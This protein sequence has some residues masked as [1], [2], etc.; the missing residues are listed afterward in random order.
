MASHP[1]V[2]VIDEFTTQRVA[3]TSKDEASR[4]AV[5]KPG[6]TDF[7]RRFENEMVV[8]EVAYKELKATRRQ[9]Y[10]LYQRGLTQVGVVGSNN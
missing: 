7:I 5:E 1:L 6:L 4:S 10:Q 2:Q 8:T 9:A 3:A